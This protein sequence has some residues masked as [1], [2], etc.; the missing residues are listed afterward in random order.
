[1]YLKFLLGSLVKNGHKIKSYKIL[2][3]FLFSLKKYYN[4]SYLT[5]FY[6]LNKIRPNILLVK[7]RRGTSVYDLPRLL[8]L[9]QEKCSAVK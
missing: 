9:N 3:N 4:N 1:M 8:S 2:C 7:K 5:L 6:S